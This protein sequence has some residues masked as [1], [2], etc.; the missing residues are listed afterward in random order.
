MRGGAVA[1][2]RVVEFTGRTLVR[3]L[4]RHLERVSPA[5]GVTIHLASVGQFKDY[6]SQ[7]DHARITLFLYRIEENTETRN[8]PERRRG[9]GLSRQP[10]GL[11]LAYMVTAWAVRSDGLAADDTATAEEQELLGTVMQA[12][13]D[14]AEVAR[15]DLVEASSGG[16]VWA[17]ID[18]LQVVLDAPGID[19]ILRIWDSADIPYRT[20]VTYRVRV[21]GL[22]PVEAF[23]SARVRDARLDVGVPG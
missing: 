21:V 12:L 5:S 15:G 23:A 10:L 7:D 18:S 20:S 19:E 6:G 3:I 13:Y 8:G 14:H 17:P 1:D 11:E 22:D 9:D 16:D 4:E 2:R